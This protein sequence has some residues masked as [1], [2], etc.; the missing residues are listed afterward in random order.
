[1]RVSQAG[2]SQAGGSKAGGSKAGGSLAGGSQAGGSQASSQ[3][4]VRSLG[5]IRFHPKT[6]SST[7]TFI[8]T[9]FHPMNIH[10][11][12]VSS[13]N[14]HVGQSKKSVFL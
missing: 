1:M 10:P 13:T 11:E 14:S 6:I 3:V 2:V 4:G 9:Q 7:D 5:R 12:T 8:Q